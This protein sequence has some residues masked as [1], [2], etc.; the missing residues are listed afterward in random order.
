MSDETP[1]AHSHTRR[2]GTPCPYLSVVEGGVWVCN[3]CGNVGTIDDELA[4]RQQAAIGRLVRNTAL[5]E[6]PEDE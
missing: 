6:V 1:M 3:K 4:E 2:D 5:G